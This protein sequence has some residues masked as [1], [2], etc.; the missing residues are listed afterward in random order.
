MTQSTPLIGA[1]KSGLEYRQ[2]DN[3]GKKALLNHHKGA[4]APSYAEAG[5]VW[6]DDSA[7]TWVLKIHDGGDWIKLFDINATENTAAAYA[8][9]ALP[10]MLGHAA[11]TGAADAYA[12]APSPAIA[13]YAQ[14]MFC[15]L[16]PANVN[17]GAATLAISG[18]SPLGIKMADGSA[19]PAGI[20]KT[21]GVYLLVHNGADFTLLNPQGSAACKDTGTSGNKV[22]LLD[23]ANTWGS[24]QVFSGGIQ[25]AGRDYTGSFTVADDAAASFVPPASNGFLFFS[26]PGN[27]RAY[28]GA[29]LFNATAVDAGIISIASGASFAVW[30]TSGALNGTSGADGVITVRA[31]AGDQKFYFENRTGTART[32]YYKFIG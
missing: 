10:Q 27:S 7:A 8:G 17:T 13:A 15:L 3:D 4:A 20:L 19:L 26:S 23:G 30:T 29:V 16:K 32:F 6:L 1:S 11:D 24:L 22:A 2:E 28:S 5:T 14:G 9:S 12:V 21:T 25:T 31:Y 18:L